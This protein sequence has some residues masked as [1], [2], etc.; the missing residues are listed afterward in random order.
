MTKA[1]IGVTVLVVGLSVV[2]LELRT[3]GQASIGSGLDGF[4]AWLDMAR[5]H[6]P[7]R[8]DSAIVRER[9]I[10]L[11]RHFTLRVDLEA[12][13]QFVR[14]PKLEHLTKSGRLYSFAEQTLLRDLAANE[15]KAGTT[16]KLLR[17]IALLESDGVMLAGGQKFI[18]P[19][20]FSKLPKDMMLSMDGIG[21]ETVV[22]PP[23]WRIARTALDAM[24]ADPAARRW[25]HQWYTATSAY[26]F[27]D[28]VLAVIPEHVAGWQR[29]LPDDGD[30]WF[31]E[32]CA[33]EVFAS[34]RIQQARLDAR[35]KGRDVSLETS[36][37]NLRQAR[38]RFALALERDPRHVEARLRL[39][40]V[41]SLLG[42]AQ[43]AVKELIAV[44]PDVGS[45]RE[46][47]YL[48]Q[49]FL[50][51]AQESSGEYAGA[52]TAYG[53]AVNLYPLALSPR[54][55]GLGLVPS[56]ASGDDGL[57]DLLRQQRLRSDDPWLSYLL[58]PGRFGPS[59]ATALWAVS[60]A[61]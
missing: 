29:V 6:T 61:Q 37:W 53:E 19:P 14:N 49:L 3:S 12:L 38:D 13:L 56:D 17:Q 4:Q 48:V 8:L 41:K 7:G 55:S 15:R 39:A 23:N 60:R 57:P 36:Y 43:A 33:F 30:A 45:D 51:A 54:I 18:V 1:T 25:I 2:P 50:G 34:S 42:E 16:D 22:T 27:Y 5:Q 28:H 11:E 32:G 58:G 9:E 44:L 21:L 47:L 59:L 26:L 20:L 31:H 40:R 35:R 10:P 24:S 46:L 52:K